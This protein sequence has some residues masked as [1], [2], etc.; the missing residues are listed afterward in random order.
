MA[1]GPSTRRA[2]PFVTT[3][4][5]RFTV[6]FTMP[7]FAVF[8]TVSVLPGPVIEPPLRANPERFPRTSK[9]LVPPTVASSSST[10]SL[11]A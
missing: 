5:L 7:K 2:P 9:R 1:V 3:M 4:D 8:F 10:M 6:A 11:R